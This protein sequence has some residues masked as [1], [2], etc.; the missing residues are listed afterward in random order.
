MLEALLATMTTALADG[1]RSIRN[2]FIAISCPAMEAQQTA[3]EPYSPPW[4]TRE[5]GAFAVRRLRRSLAAGSAFD[6]VV[7]ERGKQCNALRAEDRQRCRGRRRN[8]WP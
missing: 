4:A 8:E 3:E 5:V 6:L 2:L 1:A 7:V